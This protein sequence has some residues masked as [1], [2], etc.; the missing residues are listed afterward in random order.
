MTN[1]SDVNIILK[2]PSSEKYKICVVE[3]SERIKIYDK[4]NRYGSE[5]WACRLN[6]PNQKFDA[7]IMKMSEGDIIELSKR[8]L[9]EHSVEEHVQDMSI[10]K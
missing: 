8:L 2:H 1:G 3:E 4:I 6:F 10:I 9:K 5:E 7:D